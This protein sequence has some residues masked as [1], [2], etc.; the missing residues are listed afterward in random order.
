MFLVERWHRTAHLNIGSEGP[1]IWQSLGGLGRDRTH[2]RSLPVRKRRRQHSGSI[3]IPN[4]QLDLGDLILLRLRVV[5]IQKG[6]ITLG[7]QLAQNVV[8][9]LGNSCNLTVATHLAF[10]EFLVGLV[11]YRD[12][13]FVLQFG[14]EEAFVSS[15]L[16]GL[17]DK[18]G[19]HRAHRF[20]LAFH[21]EIKAFRFVFLYFGAVPGGADVRVI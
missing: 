7:V 13:L 1:I 12:V 3:R 21:F 8:H 6:N 18:P 20:L 15:V 9:V 4:S 10:D 19:L 17:I 2:G 16:P 11:E 14:F 5:L